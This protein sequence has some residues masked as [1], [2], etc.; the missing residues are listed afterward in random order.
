METYPDEQIVEQ[1]FAICYGFVVT[2]YKLTSLDS[3]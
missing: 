3:L 1:S 2:F